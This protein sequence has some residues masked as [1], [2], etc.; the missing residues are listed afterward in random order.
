MSRIGRR[1]NL[2]NYL[3]KGLPEMEKT[4]KDMSTH[5]LD[6]VVESV[7]EEIGRPTQRALVNYYGN[8]TG[9]H[10]SETLTRAMQHRWWSRR[11]QQGL[12]VGFSRA[13]A[14]RTLLKDGFGFK[15][16]KL[17]T[18]EGFLLRLMAWGPGVHLMEK[19]RYKH[20]K[21]NNYTG[22]GRGIAILKRFADYALQQLN[23]KIG[24]AFERAAS[25]AARANGVGR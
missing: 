17:K 8:K 25:E 23:A 2:H 14:V 24:P 11:R 10:D 4:I 1:S 20:D 18:S 7:L 6:Q 3:I 19:G 21:G 12:P 9:K 5:K 15:V 13:L 16:G 22:W